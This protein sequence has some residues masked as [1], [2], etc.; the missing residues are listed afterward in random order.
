MTV[1]N[2]MMRPSFK[3]IAEHTEQHLTHMSAELEPVLT[4]Q[5][6]YQDRDD[7]SEFPAS[8]QRFKSEQAQ[9]IADLQHRLDHL[10]GVTAGYDDQR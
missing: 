10:A 6:H 2:I 9:L 1:D 7:S 5:A 3:C 8:L 4:L